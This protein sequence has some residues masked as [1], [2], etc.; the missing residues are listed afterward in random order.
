ME[1]E[2]DVKAGHVLEAVPVVLPYP[3]RCPSFEAPYLLSSAS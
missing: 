3:S 2:L 1:E